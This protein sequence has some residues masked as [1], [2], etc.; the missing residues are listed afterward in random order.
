MES[1]YQHRSNRCG[2]ENIWDQRTNDS[3]EF[4]SVVKDDIV[5][6]S[7]R[8]F[9]SDALGLQRDEDRSHLTNREN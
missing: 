3:V 9:V 7:I 5:N 8:C 4:L 2:F 6:L 1:V